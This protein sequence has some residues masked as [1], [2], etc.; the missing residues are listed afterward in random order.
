MKRGK[1]PVNKRKEGTDYETD[2]RLH[3]YRERKRLCMEPDYDAPAIL[4]EDEEPQFRD[5]YRSKKDAAFDLMSKK[6]WSGDTKPEEEEEARQELPQALK[7][8]IRLLENDIK[9]D[10]I[11]VAVEMDV[12]TGQVSLRLIPSNGKAAAS[13]GG[14]QWKTLCILCGS[15]TGK[16]KILRP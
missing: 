3:R 10:A 11:S 4:F 9:E 6:E 13:S 14:A 15:P 2:T 16:I 5:F 7:A 1:N 12:D 8:A